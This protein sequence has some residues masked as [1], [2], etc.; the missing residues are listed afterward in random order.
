MT[1]ISS[2]ASAVSVVDSDIVVVGVII[3]RNTMIYTANVQLAQGWFRLW[4]WL[5]TVRVL[6]GKL[7]NCLLISASVRAIP[8]LRSVLS[9]TI[10]NMLVVDIML[11]KKAVSRMPT[12][13][14]F[15]LA[16]VKSLYLSKRW[17]GARSFG[18]DA[19]NAG[20]CF[21][22]DIQRSDQESPESSWPWN[23]NRY[24][25]IGVWSA[26]LRCLQAIHLQK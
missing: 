6:A 17:K 2:A 3:W 19:Q 5:W 20:S 25:G 26:S 14:R 11:I 23:R 24:L 13:T 7:D 18:L 9:L 8:H 22:E 4:M 16:D 10:K 12:Q 21:W 1:S 15:R